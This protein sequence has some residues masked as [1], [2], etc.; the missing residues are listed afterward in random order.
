MTG[1]SRESVVRGVEEIPAAV[2]TVAGTKRKTGLAA[3]AF[4]VRSVSKHVVIP[5]FSRRPAHFPTL[6]RIDEEFDPCMI[7][8]GDLRVFVDV[9]I[10]W[11]GASGPR[12]SSHSSG[13]LRP[14]PRKDIAGWNSCMPPASSTAHRLRWFHPDYLA[15]APG[16]ILPPGAS[17][18]RRYCHQ[19]NPRATSCDPNGRLQSPSESIPRPERP[20]LENDFR[21]DPYVLV[22]QCRQR[23]VLD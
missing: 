14:H 21:T 4:A 3:L 12:Y 19:R 10:G 16:G 23:A 7:G 13:R 9:Q 1:S 22:S 8:A 20:S 2:H 6:F 11:G 5:R 18:L 17:R 15:S